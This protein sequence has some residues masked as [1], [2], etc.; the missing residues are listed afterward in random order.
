[1][2]EEE[3]CDVEGWTVE[4]S[5]RICGRAGGPKLVWKSMARGA[6]TNPVARAW[7]LAQA[8]LLRFRTKRMEKTRQRM[9]GGTEVSEQEQT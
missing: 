2:A 4:D 3:L 1:M 5:L 9:E 6:R 8:W 7:R